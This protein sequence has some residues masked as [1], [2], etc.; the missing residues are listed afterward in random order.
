MRLY[1]HSFQQN[2]SS[3]VDSI[4]SGPGEFSPKQKSASREREEDEGS[5]GEG[6]KG[7]AGSRREVVGKSFILST[8][9]SHAMR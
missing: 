3:D 1:P 5:S 2:D 7:E 9:F 8:P 6:G 4:T